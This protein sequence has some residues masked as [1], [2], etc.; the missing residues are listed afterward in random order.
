MIIDE[1]RE[2]GIIHESNSPYTVPAFLVPRKDN[3]PGRLVV[4]YQALKKITI[5][6]AS[7]LPHIEDT[8]QELGKDFKYFSKLDLKT[9]YHQVQILKEDQPKTAFVVVTNFKR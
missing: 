6:D 2:A 9:G 4:D 1:F 5:P 7:L 3:R 8:L